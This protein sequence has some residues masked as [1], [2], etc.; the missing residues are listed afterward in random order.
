LDHSLTQKDSIAGAKFYL[1][2][3]VQL[4]FTI[5]RGKNFADILYGIDIR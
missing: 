2:P 3:T 5:S 4:N 1:D